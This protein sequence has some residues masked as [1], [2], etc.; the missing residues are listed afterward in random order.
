VNIL[1]DLPCFFTC[2]ESEQGD[3]SKVQ[4]IRNKDLV[5]EINEMWNML[6]QK[7]T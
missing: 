2:L 1:Y 5:V 4:L 6:G 3:V 7:D